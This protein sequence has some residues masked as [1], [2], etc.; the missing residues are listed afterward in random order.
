MN[1]IL[2][3]TPHLN[4]HNYRG[5]STRAANKPRVGKMDQGHINETQMDLDALEDLAR[6]H[7][8]PPG[9][10]RGQ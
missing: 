9:T 1:R 2:T 3:F 8:I 5:H 4:N 10:L 7:G 6:H